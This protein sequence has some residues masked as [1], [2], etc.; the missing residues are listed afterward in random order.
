MPR[1]ELAVRWGKERREGGRELIRGSI[2]FSYEY[3]NW[4]CLILLFTICR[5]CRLAAEEA[6]RGRRAGRAASASP[7]ARVPYLLGVFGS[8]QLWRSI[9]RLLACSAEEESGAS[10]STVWPEIGE[11]SGEEDHE[12]PRGELAKDRPQDVTKHIVS[13]RGERAVEKRV[14][15]SEVV[16][17]HQLQT[18]RVNGNRIKHL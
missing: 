18:M 15:G 4:L 16:T 7:S 11:L 12:G 10:R 2:G 5:L 9:L 3:E 8:N 1:L 13:G 14:M 6:R 17:L